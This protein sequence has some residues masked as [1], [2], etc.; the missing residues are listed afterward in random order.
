LRIF[1]L[2]K[3]YSKYI[4]HIGIKLASLE[5]MFQYKSNNTNFAQY[6]QVLVALFIQL[7]FVLKC[8]CTLFLEME[9]VIDI[10][11]PSH[12]VASSL[13]LL[14]SRQ[15][16]DYINPEIKYEHDVDDTSQTYL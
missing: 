8:A 9:V 6:N 13:I 11:M 3:I 7:K 2:T 15:F 10:T 16:F 5:N 1:Y 4:K 14:K 12:C